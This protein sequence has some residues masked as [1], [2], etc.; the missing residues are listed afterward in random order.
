MRPYP[1]TQWV[2]VSR[3]EPC[4]ICEKPDWCTR[5]ADGSAHCCMRMQSDTPMKNGGFLHREEGA[6]ALLGSPIAR[7][8]K[9]PEHIPPERIARS[10]ASWSIDTPDAS[11]DRLSTILGVSAESLRRVGACLA[12]PH[13]SWGFPMFDGAAKF[14]GMRLRSDDGQKWALRGSRQGIFLSDPLPT[15]D[16]L[17]VVEGPTDLAAALTLGLDGIGRPSCTG[18]ASEIASYCRTHGIRQLSIL[19]DNDGPGRSGALRLAQDL[20]S[21]RCRVATLPTKD[22]R[23]WCQSGA[24]SEGVRACIE[25]STWR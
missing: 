11:V 18:G 7:E 19:S 8:R 12:W 17:V 9:A 25:A 6:R 20:R 22:L 23:A 21:I 15:G 5:A 4:H 10:W 13:E 14:C 3:A 16:S 1:Q 2:R 24:S